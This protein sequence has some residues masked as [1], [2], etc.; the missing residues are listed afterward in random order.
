MK[1]RNTK[2]TSFYIDCFTE[3]IINY[4]EVKE[5]SKSRV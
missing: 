2:K 5:S 1:F 3:D 4:V